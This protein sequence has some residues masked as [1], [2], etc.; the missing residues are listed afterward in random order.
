M[1]LLVHVEGQ[2]EELFVGEV[3]AQ[4]LYGHGYTM[5]AARLI[6][7]ARSRNRRGG[8]RRWADVLA[9]LEIG[10]SRIRR[11]CPHLGEWLDRLE[12]LP[13]RFARDPGPT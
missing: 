4:H 13:A 8:A 9:A 5:V 10:I 1:R 3:L 12:A 2:T 11:E 6:G 7:K